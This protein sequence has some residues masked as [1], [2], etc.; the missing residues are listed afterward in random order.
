MPPPPACLLLLLLLSTHSALA[1]KICSFNV[2]SF[3]ESKKANCNAMDVIVKVIKRC[4]IILLM[5]IKDSNNRICPTLMEK[6]NGHSRRNIT[7][8]YVISSR[9]GRNTYKEQYAF[10]YKEKLVSVKQSY[11]YHDYQ[12]GD[13]DVFSREPFVVWFQSPY[14]AVK[15]FVI[16]PLHTTPETSVKEIDELADVYTD[17][18]RRWNAENFI[19]MGDFNAG[20][21]YVPKKAWKNIRLRMD[22]KFVWL[23]GDQED[24]TV[25]KSTNCAYDRIV[26]RGEEIVNSVVPQSNH[27]FDFQKAYRLSEKKALDVSDHF[28]VEFKLQFLRA[29]TNRKTSVSSKKKKKASHA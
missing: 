23:I 4:D 14:T 5:E 2:R 18:K 10:L 24:T 17:V 22:P 27:I 9:L 6:L 28:P 13:A 3:G 21:S 16:V 1:L 19:F 8:N 7:Y 26:L 20:C 25:K 12:A 15:D 11:L 29:F